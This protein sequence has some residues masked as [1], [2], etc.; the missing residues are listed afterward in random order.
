MNKLLML[1]LAGVASTA[2][3]FTPAQAQAQDAAAA[4]RAGAQTTGS[5]S[6]D[7]LDGTEKASCIARS[8]GK[9]AKNVVSDSV[10]TTKI[11]ADLVR[12]PDLKA[13][14][15]H[16]ETVKGVVKL[17]G[18]VPSTAEASKAEALA[19]GVDGVTDVQSDLKVK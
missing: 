11:K 5:V 9:K 6:C 12:D 2:F 15:V 10:I 1:T 8:T 19:R 13:M 7:D 4:S 18:F 17:S 16:V 3:A 14:D